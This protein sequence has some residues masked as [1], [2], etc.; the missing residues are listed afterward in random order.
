M[1]NWKEIF[2]KNFLVELDK[3]EK[4][5]N[6]ESMDKIEIIKSL[7]ETL[8]SS[9]KLLQAYLNFCG[10][11]PGTPLLIIKMAYYDEVIE[12]G[13]AWI[14]LHYLFKNN[15]DDNSIAISDFIDKH[16]SKRYIEIFKQLESYIL[17]EMEV[18][19]E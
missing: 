7:R 10:I 19:S 14:N 6:T 8:N 17:H 11:Y 15:S 5:F 1:T 4:L 3:L 16:F 2:N 12:D 13:Q 18:Y 9:T